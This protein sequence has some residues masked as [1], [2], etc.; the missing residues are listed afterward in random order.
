[1]HPP[2]TF[3]EFPPNTVIEMMHSSA[4]AFDAWKAIK[5]PGA[6]K[7]KLPTLEAVTVGRICEEF[8]GKHYD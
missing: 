6:D 8:G 7:A 1:M 3:S 4:E 2:R 5:V